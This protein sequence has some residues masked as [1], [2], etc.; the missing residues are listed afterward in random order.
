V[1]AGSLVFGWLTLL[2]AEYAQLGKHIFGGIVFLIN[3]ILWNES[4][5]FDSLAELKPMQHLWSLAVEEQF[6]ILWPFLVAFV[7]KRRGNFLLVASLITVCSFATNIWFVQEDP[8]LAFY[9]P[10]ARFWELVVGGI[11]AYMLVHQSN[12]GQFGKTG[13]SIV[14]FGILLI[15]LGMIKPL[16]FPGWWALLPTLGTV[17]MVS[18]GPDAWFNRTILSHRLLVWIGLVSYPLYLWHWVLLS[19]GRITNGTTMDFWP[20]FFLLFM[21]ALLAVATY[22]FIEKPIRFGNYSSDILR[23]NVIG[24]LVGIMAGLLVVALS[25]WSGYLQP[26]N[27]YREIDELYAIIGDW[28]FPGNINAVLYKGTAYPFVSGESKDATLLFGDSHIMQYYSRVASGVG[29]HRPN[30]KTVYFAS[31]P[32]CP[33]IKNLKIGSKECDR[34]IDSALEFVDTK[35]ITT[36]VVGGCWNCYLIQDERSS[37][38]AM[39]SDTALDQ[40]EQLL[41]ELSKKKETYLLLDNPR[42]HEYDPLEFISGSRLSKVYIRPMPKFIEISPAQLGLHDRMVGMA[43]RINV[44]VI[45]PFT[46]ICGSDLCIRTQSDGEPIYKDKDHLRASF[47]RNHAKYMDEVL[48]EH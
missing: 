26:R 31:E 30:S 32:G 14:G 36:V 17:L 48:Y 13:Q 4:G 27:N 9:S 18:A 19:F 5:Y 1:L 10:S 12:V 2:T 33:P 40:L 43:A 20:K 46:N 39:D 11:V 22:T 28:D 15:G 42:G 47:V 21:S 3:F 25:A 7:W 38:V 6:Y 16:E 8:K 37:E 45:D 29:E 41:V 34:F 44:K 23:R 35:Q 24:T